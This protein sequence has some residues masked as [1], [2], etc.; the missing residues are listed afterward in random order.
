M[1]TLGGFPNPPATR[2]PSRRGGQEGLSV[3]KSPKG[4]D[5]AG[6]SPAPS[7]RYSS[8][9]APSKKNSYPRAT[10]GAG[11]GT[12]VLPRTATP[13]LKR[14]RSPGRRPDESAICPWHFCCQERGCSTMSPQAMRSFRF[15]QG[16]RLE[17][18]FVLRL[19]V[20]L[21]SAGGAGFCS[22]AL[23]AD[24]D[25]PSAAAQSRTLTLSQ[26]EE[27]ALR[28]QPTLRQA[29]AQTDAALGRVE[30]ARSGYLPQ[31][32]FTGIYQ[33]A[34]AFRPSRVRASSPAARRRC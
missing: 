4:K 29:H 22:R 11:H 8:R 30:Q 2:P 31:A 10:A 16:A 9:S 17:A 24:G 27:T 5:S 6:A 7:A 12:V 21:V 15:P 28:N 1:G 14:D 19:A 25:G 20:L 34:T 26:A 33:R 13:V 18:A 3:P 23:A 32:T